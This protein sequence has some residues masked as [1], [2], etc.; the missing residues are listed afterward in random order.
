MGSNQ[1][2]IYNPAGLV[3]AESV[4]SAALLCLSL[5]TACTMHTYMLHTGNL[6]QNVIG[7]WARAARAKQAQCSQQAYWHE[8]VKHKYKKRG[9]EPNDK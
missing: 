3:L 1:R 9:D 7:N 5:T 8:P 6:S 4:F 2:A